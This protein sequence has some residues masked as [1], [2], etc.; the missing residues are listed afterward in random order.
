MR[1]SSRISAEADKDQSKN[2]NGPSVGTDCSDPVKDV[3]KDVKVPKIFYAT[4]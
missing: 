2:D 1:I 4:R 3:A